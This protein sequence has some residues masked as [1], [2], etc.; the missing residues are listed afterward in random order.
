MKKSLI[1]LICSA[2]AVISLL[3]L[4]FISASF[5]GLSMSFNLFDVMDINGSGVVVTFSIIAILAAIATAVGS[6]V[7]KNKLISMAGAVT[8]LISLFIAMLDFNDGSNYGAGIWIALICFIAN[9]VLQVI[10]IPGLDD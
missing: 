1:I 9:I 2:V 8:A 7:L 6:F 5:R 3:F 4:P 10:A